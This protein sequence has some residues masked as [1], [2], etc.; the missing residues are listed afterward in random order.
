MIAEAISK[1]QALANEHRPVKIEVKTGRATETL[2]FNPSKNEY[3]SRA[4][5]PDRPSY[6]VSEISSLAEIVAARVR[7]DFSVVIFD[8]SGASFFTGLTADGYEREQHVFSRR[9][10]PQ[11]SALTAALGDAM[12]HVQF[13]RTLQRLKPS[14]VDYPKLYGAFARVSFRKD[15]DVVSA[16]TVLAGD[17]G[18]KIEIKLAMKGGTGDLQLP[19]E[20]KVTMPLTRFGKSATFEVLIDAELTSDSKTIVFRLASPEMDVALEQLIA[21][22]VSAFREL[23]SEV[24]VSVLVNL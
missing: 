22:E 12:N 16:P 9:P 19:G 15:M 1:M 6:Q 3:E 4:L 7:G 13:L 17:A 21:H 24:P 10:S 20:F 14:I 18:S 2:V 23:V 11:W 8:G 5:V